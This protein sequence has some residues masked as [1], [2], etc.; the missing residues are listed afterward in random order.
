M[1]EEKVFFSKDWRTSS[2]VK[3]FDKFS[4]GYDAIRLVGVLFL[5]DDRDIKYRVDFQIEKYQGSVETD[6]DGDIM[7][8]R[9][10]PDSFTRST[11]SSFKDQF[12]SESAFFLS[13]G[14]RKITLK[15]LFSMVCDGLTKAK[16]EETRFA[17]KPEEPYIIKAQASH[18]RTG[19][20]SKYYQDILIEQGT[21]YGETDEYVISKIFFTEV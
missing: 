16:P 8:I 2:S 19:Y 21:L 7:I 14:K 15:K 5:Y 17:Y 10:V 12:M 13:N 3:L 18:N 9:R 20:G 11:F 6:S 1:G 4:E